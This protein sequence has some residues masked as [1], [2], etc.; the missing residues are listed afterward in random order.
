MLIKL[1]KKLRDEGLTFIFV[2]HKIEEIFE[3]ADMVT[4]LRDGKNAV[5]TN[6]GEIST[7]IE[8]IT[9]NEL[10]NRMVGEPRS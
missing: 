9:R 2:S 1:I 7:P 3:V 5:D 8:K 10:I 4:V 6:T